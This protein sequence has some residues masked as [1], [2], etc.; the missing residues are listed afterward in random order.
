MSK[1]ISF[2]VRKGGSGKTT[3]SLNV[4]FYLARM[5]QKVLLIDLDP[6]ADLTG[7]AGLKQD[8]VEND[9]IYTCLKQKKLSY[10]KLN[11]YISILPSYEDLDDAEQFFASALARESLLK[12]LLNSVK[13]EFD[14]IVI[15]CPPSTGFLT[16]NALVA[17]DF[18]FIPV[19][20]QVL[21]YKG[22]VKVVSK[23]NEVKEALNPNL[24]IGGAF[25]TMLDKRDGVNIQVKDLAEKMH[26]DLMMK[27]F[28]R[29]NVSLTELPLASQDIYSYNPNS[30][31][32]EDYLNLTKEI[33][34][35]VKQKTV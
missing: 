26:I 32:A 29:K 4:G 6:Q 14:Y 13:D 21:A 10:Y 25:L 30:N 8:Q 35:R 19:Q 34:E 31:G 7:M 9:N 2:V 1:I 3:S 27:T 28:I 23:I 22:L 16:R 24:Q 18:V 17:S 20:S 11:D 12:N 5:N 33:V 15:D